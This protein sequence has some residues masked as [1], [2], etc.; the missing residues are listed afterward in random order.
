MPRNLWIDHREEDELR[1]LKGAAQ[2]L[3]IG[4]E[5]L[6]ARHDQMQN[7]DCPRCQ[8]R[9]HH[10]SHKGRV[11]IRFERCNQCKGSYFD[12]GEFTDYVTDDI[13][14]EFE[15]VM[16]ELGALESGQNLVDN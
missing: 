12:A 15:N 10:F 16:T 5:F 4:D 1:N 9:L 11:E 13:F 2:V 14:D 6:W 7:I 8:I 3:D